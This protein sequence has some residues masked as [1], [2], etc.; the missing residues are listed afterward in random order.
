VNCFEPTNATSVVQLFKTKH[1][2]VAPFEIS[3]LPFHLEVSAPPSSLSFKAFR[4]YMVTYPKLDRSRLIRRHMSWV[5]LPA[6]FFGWYS[7]PY[8]F[9]SLGY[10]QRLQISSYSICLGALYAVKNM[11]CHISLPQ[12]EVSFDDVLSIQR[13]AASHLIGYCTKARSSKDE[14]SSLDSDVSENSFERNTV[15][16]TPYSPPLSQDKRAS[17]NI[18]SRHKNL[19]WRYYFCWLWPCFKQRNVSVFVR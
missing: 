19:T 16:W 5:S 12:G 2:P 6:Q 18:K 15:L 4:A 1:I 14:C 7:I 8:N 13:H 9:D 17:P 11:T 3:N 10:T